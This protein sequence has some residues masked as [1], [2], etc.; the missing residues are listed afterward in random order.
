MLEF[1]AIEKFMKKAFKRHECRNCK[2]AE[3]SNCKEFFLC[4]RPQINWDL[5]PMLRLELPE[6]Y[7]I[8]YKPPIGMDNSIEKFT[9]IFN[10]AIGFNFLDT[11][12]SG[13]P[14]PK[15]YGLLTWFRQIAQSMNIKLA[16]IN[17]MFKGVK[18]YGGSK[19]A[20]NRDLDV[21][22]PINCKTIR[23]P[24]YR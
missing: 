10:E 21:R 3:P 7:C 24:K 8:K 19:H 11:L 2:Y 18:Y 6:S 13:K 20:L 14:N 22:R 5:P 9:D 23:T 15:K 1:Y 12:K 16:E 4:V 17:R